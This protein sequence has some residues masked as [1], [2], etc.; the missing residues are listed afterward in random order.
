[1]GI[2]GSSCADNGRKII[3]E[4]TDRRPCKGALVVVE[5]YEGTLRELETNG[6]GVA[7]FGNL[8]WAFRGVGVSLGPLEFYRRY[9][10]NPPPPLRL[11]MPRVENEL[12]V[13]ASQCRF[14][15]VDGSPVVGLEVALLRDRSPDVIEKF[16]TDSEG[17]ISIQRAIE[18][19]FLL[20]FKVPQPD[21]VMD[22][23]M[24]LSEYVGKHLAVKIE[25]P[26]DTKK[27]SK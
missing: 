2:V 8:S 13:P 26:G 7:E 16:H 5:Y 12:G 17:K 25:L 24:K 22:C 14:V 27:G 19:D 11:V 9:Y 1:M 4:G 6:K 23:R 20:S 18:R 3:V 15:T 21:G 10:S